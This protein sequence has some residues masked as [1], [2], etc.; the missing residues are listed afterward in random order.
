MREK[1]YQKPQPGSVYHKE[2]LKSV[3]NW[4]ELHFDH[5]HFLLFMACIGACS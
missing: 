3:V 1:I 4:P 5:L 2:E